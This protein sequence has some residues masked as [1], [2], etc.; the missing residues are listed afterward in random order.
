[1]T[2]LAARELTNPERIDAVKGSAL[3]VTVRP[4]G[5]W[6]IRFG[7]ATLTTVPARAATSARIV[8]S[9]SSYLAIE[10]AASTPSQW[11]RR[12]IAVSVTP[13]RAPVVRIERPGKDLVFADARATVPIAAAASDDYGLRS[14]ELRY[15]RVSGS[16]EQFEF[17]E[18]TLPLALA[19]ENDRSW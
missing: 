14:L 9:E 2:G 4:A 6:R 13:D 1:Y 5:D 17:Q 19:R 11:D 16:G 7:A 18:G 12:L 15:T 10:R 3:T 8:L